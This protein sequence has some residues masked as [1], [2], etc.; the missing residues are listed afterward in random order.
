MTETKTGNDDPRVRDRLHYHNLNRITDDDTIVASYGGAGQT[1]LSNI[2]IRLGLNYVNP[3]TEVL[4]PDGTSIPDE[5]AQ[6]YR[7][8]FE[9]VH[10]RDRTGIVADR[11]SE[12]RFVKTHLFEAEFSTLEF[13]GVWLLVRD[14][15]D[16]LYS[17]YRFR[18]GFAEVAWERVPDS[19]EEFVR[20]PDHTGNLP[21]DDWASF[22][23]AWLNRARGCRR[24]AITRFED[25]KLDGV[26]TVRR[27]LSAFGLDCATEQ[28]ERAVADSAF[29]RMRAHEDSVADFDRDKGESRIM[30][31]GK[32]NGWH[33]WMTPEIAACFSGDRARSVARE[34]GYNMT[35]HEDE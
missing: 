28:I 26:P 17:F 12:R 14:P 11:R 5:Q 33:N 8:R 13:S 7:D 27:A 6:T 23:T 29:E 25:L 1:L 10:H 2:L 20:N 34:F 15:R 3:A 19:F 22:Y 31:A 18:Q 35:D 32:V 21:V 30:R 9:A 4:L 24:M 16:A